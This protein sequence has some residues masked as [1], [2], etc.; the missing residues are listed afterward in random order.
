[1]TSG[2]F[3]VVF[4]MV[5]INNDKEYA[6]KCFLREQEGREKS[7]LKI[8][9]ELE[10]VDS[11][12]ILKTEYLAGELFVDTNQS[13]ETDFPILLMDWVEGL[14]LGAYIKD[15][16]TNSIKLSQLAYYF[17]KM[18]S[19]LLTQDFA[20][21]DIKPDNIIVKDNGNLV[22]VDYDGM[23]VPSMK[24][25]VARENGSPNFR[26]PARTEN[27]FDEHIDDFSLAVLNLTLNFCSY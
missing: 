21:G 7:Y 27:D 13:D 4:K 2:N 26:H 15:N 5:D 10:F 11:I 25:S 22:L 18:A 20:H 9:E 19:W 14:T 24:G 8:C 16:I 23:Y 1:M 6:M 12:Y 17:S 3:A